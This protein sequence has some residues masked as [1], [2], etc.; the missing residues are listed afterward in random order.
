MFYNFKAHGGITKSSGN[1]NRTIRNSSECQISVK[2]RCDALSALRQSDTI[3]DTLRHACSCDRL[4]QKYASTIDEDL[5][6]TCDSNRLSFTIHTTTE[7]CQIAKQLAPMQEVCKID[8]LLHGPKCCSRISDE[9]LQ[10]GIRTGYPLTTSDPCWTDRVVSSIVG[11]SIDDSEISYLSAR[12]C[13]VTV[14]YKQGIKIRDTLIILEYS[15]VPRRIFGV[16][17]AAL[18]SSPFSFGKDSTDDNIL[19]KSEN[20]NVN[21]NTF[22][23]LECIL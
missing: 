7:D 4:Y 6:V 1:C 16:K 13:L 22:F 23:G 11:M 8:R 20:Y 2:T 12:P 10:R 17:G 19:F 21:S 5:Y 9:I 14:I 3:D 15:A 18:A